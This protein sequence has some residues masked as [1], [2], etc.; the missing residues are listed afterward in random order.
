MIRSYCLAASVLIGI[1]GTAVAQSYPSK[2]VRIVVPSVPGG[3]QDVV[4]RA[5]AQK[6]AEA[7]G[8]PVI[9]ENRAGAGGNI[10]AEAVARAAPD[11]HSILLT[12]AGL[13]IAPSLYRKLSYDPVKDLL[14]VSQV[15]S[16]FLVLVT[17]PSLPPT[18]KELIALAKAQ[19]GKLNYY[20]FGSGS[21]LHLT[22][23]MFSAA[24]GIE[25]TNVIYK[26]DGD[27]IPAMLRNDIQM[28]FLNPAA[29]VSHVKAGKL[30]ALAVS[31]NT[32]GSVFP[33]VPTMAELGYPDV[34]YVGFIGFFVPAG[35]PRDVVNKIANETI[36]VVRL[37]EIIEKMPVW[38]GES[39]GT[40]PEAF[41][42]KYRDD[43][44]RY[45]R[46]IKSANVPLAD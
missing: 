35:T 6:F 15:M 45:A 32:R 34:N 14:P 7:W 20:H 16:T 30:R 40:T 41:A 28:S 18:V 36:R 11:G 31:G 42:A 38:G 4:A 12:T 13:A 33:D 1:S 8:Q 10:A 5:M 44:A 25:F 17:H 29:A 27:A 26:G 2:T 43:I 39:A 3:G 46:I 19:P 37:P 22:G 21:G 9:A 24:A 23:E